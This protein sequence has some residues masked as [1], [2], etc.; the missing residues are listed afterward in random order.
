MKLLNN[1][2]SHQFKAVVKLR[3]DYYVSFIPSKTITYRLEQAVYSQIKHPG[4]F[5]KSNYTFPLEGPVSTISYHVSWI[6]EP[7]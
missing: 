6:R 2:I 4:L 7:K 3:L 1:I 5:S